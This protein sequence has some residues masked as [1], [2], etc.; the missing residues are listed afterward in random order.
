MMKKEASAFTT[1]I[2]LMA[3]L[4]GIFA[5]GMWFRWE[6]RKKQE[7]SM[8]YG[9]ACE[10]DR[11]NFKKLRELK[12]S[13]STPQLEHMALAR[14]QDCSAETRVAAI[15][16]LSS[17]GLPNKDA[18]IS[19]LEI[20]HPFGVRH[21]AVEALLQHGCDGLCVE[22]TLE[23]LKALSKG[24]PASE[25]KAEAEMETM[26]IGSAPSTQGLKLMEKSRQDLK[27]LQQQAQNDYFKLLQ[28]NPCEAQKVLGTKYSSDHELIDFV[29]KKVSG[30]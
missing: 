2:A 3:C 1:Y 16:V 8:I 22:S 18:L 30:C 19:L 13:E 9:F 11:T 29:Q 21:A 17:R 25:T 12:P 7:L 15:E 23:A 4:L 14:E 27:E 5:S 10:G 6:T 26:L 20:D 28:N 24:Q